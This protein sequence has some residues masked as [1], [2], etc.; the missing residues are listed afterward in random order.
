MRPT[1][2]D[3]GLRS[4][5]SKDLLAVYESEGKEYIQLSRWKERARQQVSKYPDPKNCKI[6]WGN[7]G[8][9]TAN[10]SKCCQL[11]ASPPSPSP[12]PSPAPQVRR[13]APPTL[14][15]VKLNGAKIGLPDSECVKFYAFYE[16]NGW[17]VGKN[18]MK[19]WNGAMV[20]WKSTWTE[21][22]NGKQTQVIKA[23]PRNDGIIRGK[24]DYGEAAA[25]KLERQENGERPGMARQVAPNTGGAPAVGTP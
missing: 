20:H 9:M 21:R 5:A 24:T 14:D 10:D 6:V 12:T 23:N 16:S 25:R 4:L 18:P 19:S 8:Q 17:R 7:A 15:E 3:G 2:V 1:T 22:N 11:H 13:F